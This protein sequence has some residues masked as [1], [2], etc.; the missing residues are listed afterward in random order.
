MV[1]KPF[2]AF[3]LQAFNGGTVSSDTFKGKVVLLDFWEVWC[4]P[5]IASMPKVQK[6]YEQYKD[7]NFLAYGIMNETAQLQSS[8]LLVEKKKLAFPGS[9][10]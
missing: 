9:C 8:K 1:G 5:C 2:S 7:K 10:R 3:S 6:L 4:G